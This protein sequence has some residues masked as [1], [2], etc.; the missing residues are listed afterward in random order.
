MGVAGIRGGAMALE[1]S[2]LVQSPP[3]L[4]GKETG[5]A[6]LIEDGA[7]GKSCPLRALRG[8]NFP[9]VPQEE[10]PRPYQLITSSRCG[11]EGE[12]GTVG[13]ECRWQSDIKSGFRLYGR[14]HQQ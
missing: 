10:E 2:A 6:F 8:L 7:W 14:G 1:K 11:T 13:L 12:K 9:L 5:L 3:H 4:A